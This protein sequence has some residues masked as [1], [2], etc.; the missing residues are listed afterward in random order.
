MYCRSPSSGWTTPKLRKNT[1]LSSSAFRAS[2]ITVSARLSGC[3]RQTKGHQYPKLQLRM[4][5]GLMQVEPYRVRLVPS[6]PAGLGR[7]IRALR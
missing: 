2:T 4:V 5:K 1:A 7:R 6:G 3:A